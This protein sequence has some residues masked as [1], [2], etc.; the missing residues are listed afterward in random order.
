MMH[1]SCTQKAMEA[2]A[3]IVW[4]SLFVEYSLMF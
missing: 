1:M 3:P 2:E 4:K